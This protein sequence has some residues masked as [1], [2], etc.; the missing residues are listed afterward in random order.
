MIT[1]PS[2]LKALLAHAKFPHSARLSIYVFNV[3]VPLLTALDAGESLLITKADV[4]RG[5]Q[6]FLTDDQFAR[7]IDFLVKKEVLAIDESV[8]PKEF[9][10][11][12]KGIRLPTETSPTT[13]HQAQYSLKK[14]F[15][16]LEDRVVSL[17]KEVETLADE[18]ARCRSYTCM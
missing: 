10:R 5:I 1:K 8:A 15:A 18:V 3:A 4:E 6:R 2:S 17:E 12:G 11:R 13:K 7:L 16:A 9:F 14:R